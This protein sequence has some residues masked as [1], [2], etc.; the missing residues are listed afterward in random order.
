MPSLL[1]LLVVL[2]V[3]AGIANGFTLF[4]AR[5]TQ[6]GA[7]IVMKATAPGQ[8][9]GNLPR[10]MKRALRAVDTKEKLSSFYTPEFDSFLKDE[11]LCSHG[12]HER[13]MELIAKKAKTLKTSVKSDFGA[14]PKVAL[15]SIV[16]TAAAAGTFNTL[17][18]AVKA[19]GLLDTLKGGPFTVLAPTDEAFSKLP[20]GALDGL[21][22]DKKKLADVLK[23][24]LV[25][26]FVNAN[27]VKTLKDKNVVSL[28]E[29]QG[30]AVK[31][32]F[33]TTHTRMC[34]TKTK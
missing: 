11:K 28:L 13:L 12:I 24:H 16:D 7:M 27:V 2:A 26:G 10:K 18:T 17:I 5:Q 1:A 31:V 4:T 25:S 21:L 20:E 32:E 23:Y 34:T 22:A 6:R 29:G 9:L 19:A 14:K 30:A 33:T 15:P 8:G 3:V